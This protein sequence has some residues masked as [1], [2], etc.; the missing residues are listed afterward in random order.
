MR[1]LASFTLV[2]VLILIGAVGSY[3]GGGLKSTAVAPETVTAQTDTATT[4][5]ATAEKSENDSFVVTPQ[6]RIHILVGDVKGGGHKAGIG[7][8]GKTEFPKE[9]SDDKI[10]DTAHTIANDPKVPMRPSGKYWVKAKDVD[11]IKV[12]VVLD[13]EK[14]EVVTSYPLNTPRN[15]SR[16]Q[17]ALEE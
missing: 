12:R 4:T 5:T 9:W 14:G 11:G 3:F 2:L 8:P 7:K 13:R 15:K 1:N 17:M 16:R 10:I 6:R